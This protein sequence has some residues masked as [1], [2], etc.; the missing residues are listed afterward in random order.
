MKVILN[1]GHENK[2]NNNIKI[3]L[4]VVPMWFKIIIIT[5]I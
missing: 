2:N 3:Q 5:S 4:R 1:L